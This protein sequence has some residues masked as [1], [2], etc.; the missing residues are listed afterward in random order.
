MLST[1]FARFTLPTPL[2]PP[3]VLSVVM[4]TGWEVDGGCEDGLQP[5][6]LISLTAPK[7]CATSFRGKYHVLGGRFVLEQKF[8]LNLP[9]NPSTDPIVELK[10]QTQTQM[11]SQAPSSATE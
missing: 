2:I 10:T 7:K 6:L 1:T 4:V 11:Q 9:P 8:N 5:Q 3:F